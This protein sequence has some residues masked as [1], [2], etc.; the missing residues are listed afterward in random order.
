MQKVLIMVEGCRPIRILED[1]RND[2]TLEAPFFLRQLIS[3]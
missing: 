2:H 1:N 3:R